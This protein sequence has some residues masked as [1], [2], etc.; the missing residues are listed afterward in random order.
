[1]ASEQI[2]QLAN[3]KSAPHSTAPLPRC[4]R[5]LAIATAIIFCISSAFP[6]VAAFV[7]DTE[8][9]PKWW[10][11]LDV[12]IAFF[13][14]IL[15]LALLGLAQGKVNKQAEGASYRA[16]RILTHGILA[17]LVVFFLIGD[18]IVWSNCLTGFAWRAWLLLY[19]LPAWFTA[20]SRIEPTTVSDRG[21]S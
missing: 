2:N 3:P 11:V 17:G 20:M 1:M 6:A 9:W 16:Y 13:L 4:G 19:S 14:A 15:A 8:S 12:G 10:G 18:R 5:P 7:R 21:G